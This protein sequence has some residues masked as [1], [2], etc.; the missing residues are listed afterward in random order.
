MISPILNFTFGFIQRNRYIFRYVITRNKKIDT[1]NC[2]LLDTLVF[3]I[4]GNAYTVLYCIFIDIYYTLANDYLYLFGFESDNFDFH[5]QSF[6][7]LQLDLNWESARIQELGI[8]HD[9]II[10][11]TVLLIDQPYFKVLLTLKLTEKV[12]EVKKLM[13]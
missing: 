5:E 13:E 9:T 11:I 8:E 7:S 6:A 2:N 1:T 3:I 10:A 12:G 4:D